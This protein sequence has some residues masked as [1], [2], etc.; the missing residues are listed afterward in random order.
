VNGDAMPEYL[1]PWQI[2]RCAAPQPP[3]SLCSFS[4]IMCQ[5]KCC[6]LLLLSRIAFLS[7]ECNRFLDY[8]CLGG[9]GV[10]A[11]FS[12]EM[13]MATFP[14][15]KYKCSMWS[16]LQHREYFLA[17]QCAPFLTLLSAYSQDESQLVVASLRRGLQSSRVLHSSA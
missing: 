8:W 2:C 13:H 6:S 4:V 16:A 12:K 7:S 14:M 1:Q 3:S 5:W 10:T 9:G 17:K 15:R 11:P